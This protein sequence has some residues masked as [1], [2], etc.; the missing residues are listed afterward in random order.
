MVCDG[1]G[2]NEK[3]DNNAKTSKKITMFLLLLRFLQTIS[4]MKKKN[5]KRSATIWTQLLPNL[6]DIR[7]HSVQFIHSC[8]NLF[9]ETFPHFIPP[10]KLIFINTKPPTPK[11]SNLPICALS[12]Q[13][14]FSQ[15]RTLAEQNL[16]CYLTSF[17]QQITFDYATQSNST[18]LTTLMSPFLVDIE[19]N[20]CHLVFLRCTFVVPSTN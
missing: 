12:V 14:I 6:Q 10:Q 1:M 20:S 15:L 7:D 8:Q 9:I 5:T 16:C 17:L 19:P 13:M 3:N 4:S 18:I 11:A 2:H